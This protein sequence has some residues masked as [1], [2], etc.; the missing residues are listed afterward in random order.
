[1]KVILKSTSNTL[2]T[3]CSKRA[4]PTCVVG[5]TTI[6]LNDTQFEYYM[7]YFNVGFRVVQLATVLIWSEE[8]NPQNL[9]HN[10]ICF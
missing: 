8:Q 4:K 5:M 9:S 10:T 3:L 6:H 1:M 2:R 7:I